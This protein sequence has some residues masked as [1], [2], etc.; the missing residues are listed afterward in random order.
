[1]LSVLLLGVDSCMSRR[2]TLGEYSL[3]AICFIQS[4]EQVFLRKIMLNALFT[5]TPAQCAPAATWLDLTL[6]QPTPPRYLASAY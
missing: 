5:F 6:Q 2:I 4:P 3:V 1:M